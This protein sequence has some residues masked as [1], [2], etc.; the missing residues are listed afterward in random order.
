MGRD[1]R[2]SKGAIPVYNREKFPVLAPATFATD[3]V[4]SDLV[5]K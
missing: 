5:L 4:I 1:G 3:Q 2:L